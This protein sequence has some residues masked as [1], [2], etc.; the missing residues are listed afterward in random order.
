M[1]LN[2]PNSTP[3]W[4]RDLGVLSCPRYLVN[5]SGLVIAIQESECELWHLRLPCD[6]PDVKDGCPPDN[7]EFDEKLADVGDTMIFDIRPDFW[8]YFYRKS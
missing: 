8:T 1:A 5:S 7:G 2:I 4:I 6:G 3:L